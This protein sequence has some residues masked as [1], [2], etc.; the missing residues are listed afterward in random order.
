M[1]FQT[2]LIEGRLLRRYKRFLADVE[3]A[4]GE[5]V[6][7]HCPNSGSMLSVKDPGSAVWISRS[8]VA[9]RKLAYTWELIRVADTLVGIN[10]NRPNRIVAEALM[11]GTIAELTGYPTIRPEVRYDLNSRI[12]L[13]LS[14]D[15][16]PP[17]YVEIKN[18]TLKRDPAPDGDVQFPDAVTARGL[19]HLD[20][21]IGR[22]HAGERAA[23][24]YLAQRDDCSTLSFAG[25]I[26][27]AYAAGVSRAA[28][29]GVEVLAYKCQVSCEAIQVV[30]RIPILALNH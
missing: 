3:L 5:I 18:V 1:R 16:R 14:G 7:A 27:P 17:C 20:A 2:P 21:L 8:E 26:D 12:D 29:A 19:K 23:M 25:D 28:A 30:G 6:T 9:T 15:G 4:S 22:V 11:L 10:T 13:L 24:L